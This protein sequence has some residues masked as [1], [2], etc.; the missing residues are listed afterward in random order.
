MAY[1]LTGDYW[2]KTA[3][4]YFVSPTVTYYDEVVQAFATWDYYIDL[5]F[6]ITSSANAADIR[7]YQ[8]PIDGRDG[9]IGEAYWDVWGGST[10]I[11]GADVYLDRAD[12]N[13]VNLGSQGTFTVALHEIGHA[14]GLD[15][16]NDPDVIMSAFIDLD[17][18]GLQADDIAG[19]QSL[20][21]AEA[22]PNGWT[23]GWTQVYGQVNTFD[24]TFGWQFGWNVST[25]YGWVASPTYSWYIDYSWA[26]EFGWGW[27]FTNTG[28]GWGFVYD[29]AFHL[30]QQSEVIIYQTWAYEL[31]WS[32]GWT[33]SWYQG[34]GWGWS[35][36]WGWTGGWGW[37]SA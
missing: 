23:Y 19:A 20:Y 13:P 15:H 35:T 9:V 25:F 31:G 30:E 16:P 11:T 6:T 4:T 5:D 32:T 24:F 17:L 26:W 18:V 22:A 14:I 36:T 1:A 21:G 2:N 28:S 7:V 8:A 3:L 37:V 34:W 12:A 10:V 27:T 29:Q 33:V